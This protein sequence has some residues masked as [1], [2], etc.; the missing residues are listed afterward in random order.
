M[1]GGA[2]FLASR[3]ICVTRPPVAPFTPA[4]R[5]GMDGLCDTVTPPLQGVMPEHEVACH[6]YDEALL[7]AHGKLGALVQPGELSL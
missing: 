7:A 5:R 3:R 2:G 4:V 1:N 6:L